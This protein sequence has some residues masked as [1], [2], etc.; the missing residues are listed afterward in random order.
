MSYV[1]QQNDYDGWYNILKVDE[2]EKIC[3]DA[4]PAFY[5]EMKS[6]AN[7]KVSIIVDHERIKGSLKDMLSNHFNDAEEYAYHFEQ[8][9]NYMENHI[10]WERGDEDMMIPEKE[11][12]VIYDS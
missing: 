10:V 11:Y 3:E 2:D 7:K 6:L 12:L 1:H 4:S 5:E 8:P 9:T